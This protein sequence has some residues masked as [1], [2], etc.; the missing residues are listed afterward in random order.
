MTNEINAADARELAARY[1]E[2]QG[3]GDARVGGEI[4]DFVVV[5]EGGEYIVSV[6]RDDV[7]GQLEAM[8]G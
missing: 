2:V 6:A 8:V 3:C 7:T 5:N 4:W 1:G